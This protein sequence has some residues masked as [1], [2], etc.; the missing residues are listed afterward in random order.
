MGRFVLELLLLLIVGG[1]AGI[2]VYQYLGRGQHDVRPGPATSAALATP[3][4]RDEIPE[5]PVWATR[6]PAGVASGMY[7][8]TAYNDRIYHLLLRSAK[9]TWVLELADDQG[10]PVELERGSDKRALE[11]RF[12]EVY[13]MLPVELENEEKYGNAEIS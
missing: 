11:R 7:A 13:Q 5:W 8:A 12:A 1:V 2:L 10:T 6:K 3:F 4:Q 9:N